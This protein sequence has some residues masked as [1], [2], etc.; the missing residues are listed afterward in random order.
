[1]EGERQAAGGEVIPPRVQDAARCAAWG[2]RDGAQGF[3]DNGARGP[4]R[5]YLCLRRAAMRPGGA[6]SLAVVKKS[7]VRNKSV[8]A[9]RRKVP[10]SKRWGPRYSAKVGR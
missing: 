5:P 2:A 10:N 3:S 4:R 6:W 7:K 8:S 1:M 9:Q